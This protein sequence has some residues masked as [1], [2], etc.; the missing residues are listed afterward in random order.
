MAP[1]RIR[2][3]ST[4]TGQRQSPHVMEAVADRRRW[5]TTSAGAGAIA[6]LVAPFVPA[7]LSPSLGSI[8]HV[9]L[10]FPLVAAPLAV[11]LLATFSTARLLSLALRV[12]PVAGALVLV[13]FFVAT[14]RLAGLL[15]LPWL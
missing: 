5:S 6:W 9:F 15:S 7:R 11:L 13:S 12:Q 2:G 3:V 4:R 8:E 1:R 10:L 14:G